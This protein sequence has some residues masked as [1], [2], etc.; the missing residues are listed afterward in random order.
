MKVY[1]IQDRRNGKFLSG[2][3]WSGPVNGSVYT[4]LTGAKNGVGWIKQNT[5]LD[6]E[7]PSPIIVVFDCYESKRILCD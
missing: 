2:R 6:L 7:K 1:K 4:T 3:R 5:R